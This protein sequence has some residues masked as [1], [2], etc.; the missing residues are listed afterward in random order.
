MSFFCHGLSISNEQN[1]L[2]GH[3]SNTNILCLVNNELMLKIKCRFESDA[4]K[5]GEDRE[6]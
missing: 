3:D 6:I 2:A 4:G 1:Y 5:C